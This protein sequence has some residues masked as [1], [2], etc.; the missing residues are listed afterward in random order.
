M[1]R[2]SLLRPGQ[3]VV[4]AAIV[5]VTCIGCAS[6]PK[7]A[8][9]APVPPPPATLPPPSPPAAP[10]LSPQEAKAQAQKQALEA[11]DH[12]QN[13]DEAAA[14]T[15]LEQA[16]RADPSNELARK[17]MDQVRADAQ[18]EL[19]AKSFAY[20]AQPGDSMSKLAE[21][22]LG[23]RMRFYILAKYNGIANPSKLAAGQVIKI[24]GTK[25]PSPP[26]QAQPVRPTEPSKSTEVSKPPGPAAKAPESSASER[27][28]ADRREA[29]R[30][31][32]MQRY[33]R[34]AMA[35][36]HKQDLD[37][38]IKKWD[39]LLQLDPDN[40]TAKYNRARALDLKERLQKFPTQ[41]Q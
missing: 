31:A 23:D 33:N 9:P 16:L 34:E 18:Q 19:G 6:A 38:A 20:T 30:Q 2:R 10:A 12:L 39:Q 28:Q 3:F 17:L 32:L 27:G 15:D 41:K 22:F 35:A 37:T 11:R 14:Q 29:E 21:R 4:I 40:E 7:P 13:G 24:P 25:P 26:P 1:V 8:E 36:Y 5:A